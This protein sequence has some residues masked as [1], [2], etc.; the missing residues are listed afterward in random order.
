MHP[1][2]A[3]PHDHRPPSLPSTARTSRQGTCKNSRKKET[4]TVK[5]EGDENVPD[6]GHEKEDSNHMLSRG[7]DSHQD[8]TLV[9]VEDHDE[10]DDEKDDD[11]AFDPYHRDPI[12]DEGLKTA[13]EMLADEGDIDAL[14]LILV[15]RV[16]KDQYGH[17]ELDHGTN[18]ITIHTP[19]GA[20]AIVHYF[21]KDQS[22]NQPSL[23]RVQCENAAL[24]EK[25]LETLRKLDQA[26]LPIPSDNS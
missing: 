19:T 9:P 16:L 22:Q 14:H 8:E 24:R 15:Y 18:R 1:H 5:K 13:V 2:A 20:E 7:E 17:V 25:L 10:K 6:E 4:L 23:R 21:E 26:L 11:D 3:C 12:E